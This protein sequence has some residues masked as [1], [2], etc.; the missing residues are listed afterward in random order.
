M[1]EPG[2]ELPQRGLDDGED[3]S[4]D[5]GGAVVRGEDELCSGDPQLPRRGTVL[6]ADCVVRRCRHGQ[7]ALHRSVLSHPFPLG[8]QQKALRISAPNFNRFIACLEKK[9]SP[10]NLKI[11]DVWNDYWSPV[12]SFAT[13]SQMNSSSCSSGRWLWNRSYWTTIPIKNNK[14]I[15]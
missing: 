14:R 8:R 11:S 12:F 3:S 5:A 9:V 7:H 13:V 6:A 10:R 1:R 4:G 15:L 2:L